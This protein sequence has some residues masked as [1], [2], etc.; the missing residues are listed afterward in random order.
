MDDYSF[1]SEHGPIDRRNYHVRVDVTNARLLC[2]RC[3]KNKELKHF[4]IAHELIEQ[5]M[6]F[7]M[8][9][10]SCESEDCEKDR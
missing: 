6:D 2:D 9:H 1:Y 5:I 8:A 4:I 10:R 7:M 3:K